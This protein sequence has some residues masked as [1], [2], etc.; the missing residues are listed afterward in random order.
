[1]NS[2]KE[3]YLSAKNITK[4]FGT[5][6]V[7]DDVSMEIESGDVV[8]IIGPSGA[9]KS[10]FLRCMNLLETPTSGKVEIGDFSITLA[11]GRN[12][13][14]KKELAALRRN[15]GMVFQSFNLFPH[16]T[17][18][19]NICLAQRRVLGRSKDEAQARALQL[20]ERVGLK[21]KAGEYPGRCSGGQQQRVAIARSLSLD[22][23]VML[24]DEP[25]SALDPEVGAEI[26]AV[27]RELAEDGMTMMVV[28][29]EMGFARQVGDKVH[30]MVDG[31]IV[32]SGTPEQVM[33]QPTHERTRQFLSA[34]L[35]R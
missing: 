22:P 31:R 13:A 24:F 5:T 33:T 9:G 27:M 29:H 8:S 30:V 6:R 17:V 21:D 12:S 1:M 32:E 34:V 20:L 28:T 4:D 25:T 35:G 19:E 23:K 15:V 11:P 16:L 26:L 2:Q 3:I 18:L 7:L 10:T 14:S